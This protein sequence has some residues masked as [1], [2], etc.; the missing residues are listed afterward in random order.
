MG[1]SPTNPGRGAPSLARLRPLAPAA[2]PGARR[3]KGR[4]QDLLLQDL[5]HTAQRSLCPSAGAGSEAWA[6]LPVV[7]ESHKLPLNTPGGE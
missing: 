4:V 6:C 3:R 1:L 2:A 5:T 7:G